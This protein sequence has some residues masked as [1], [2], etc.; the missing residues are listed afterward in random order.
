M[1]DNRRSRVITQGVARTPN[2][3]MLR[4][5]GFT[6]DDFDKPIVGVGNAHSTI[7]PCNLGI[8]AQAERAEAALRGPGRCR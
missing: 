8:G 3:A 2:R 6:D 4:A 1:A 7:T 5:V